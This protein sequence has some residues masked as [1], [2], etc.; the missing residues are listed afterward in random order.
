MKNS[1]AY[2]KA[3]RK[4]HRGLQTEGRERFQLDPQ[5]EI[6]SKN[7]SKKPWSPAFSDGECFLVEMLRQSHRSLGIMKYGFWLESALQNRMKNEQRINWSRSPLSCHGTCRDLRCK[8][9][10][11][12]EFGTVK[13]DPFTKNWQNLSYNRRKD[14]GRLNQKF[15]LYWLLY[16]VFV[17]RRNLEILEDPARLPRSYTCPTVPS[18]TNICSLGIYYLFSLSTSFCLFSLMWFKNLH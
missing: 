3:W 13:R 11:R 12:I 5:G 17:R 4:Q 10:D 8:L 15:M 2:W 9:L 1:N 18:S 16:L 6:L 14:S 7:A